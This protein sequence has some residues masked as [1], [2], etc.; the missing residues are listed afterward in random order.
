M[1]SGWLHSFWI[2]PN[3]QCKPNRSLRMRITYEKPLDDIFKTDKQTNRCQGIA[4]STKILVGGHSG[5]WGWH[6]GGGW[7][8]GAPE[9]YRLSQNTHPPQKGIWSQ[10]ET[11]A[12]GRQ[13]WEK[14]LQALSCRCVKLAEGL[15]VT[16]HQG[17][18]AGHKHWGNCR[19]RM[20]PEQG[21]SPGQ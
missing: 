8:K 11:R 13:N 16:D 4:L 7:C 14:S 21:R 6:Q 12:M 10:A 5:R 3:P 1:E 18:R 15:R 20:C 19:S 2:S 9:A 17:A